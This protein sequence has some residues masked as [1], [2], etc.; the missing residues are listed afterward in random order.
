LVVPVSL[1]KD[2]PKADIVVVPTLRSAVDWVS[3]RTNHLPSAMTMASRQLARLAD[4][5]ARANAQ[6]I[7]EH[8]L[9]MP[10]AVQRVLNRFKVR[11]QGEMY[12]ERGFMRAPRSVPAI[13]PADLA[14]LRVYSEIP[15][16]RGR[17]AWWPYMLFR[18]NDD[19]GQAVVDIMGRARTLSYGPYI[20]LPTGRWRAR[21]LIGLSKAAAGYDYLVEFGALNNFSASHYRPQKPGLR[22]V[23]VYHDTR[24]YELLE[25]RISLLRAAFHGEFKF[26][27][28]WITKAD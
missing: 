24:N 18:A 20:A 8:E 27:G 26:Y 2:P 11:R 17:W 19:V 9:T 7:E 5:A 23:S 25:V 15:V 12:V 10:S 6:I 22:F 16:Q 3:A 13:I 21:V 4:V 28:A 14:A 1:E